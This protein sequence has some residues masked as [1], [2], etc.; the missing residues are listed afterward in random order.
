MT[1]SVEEL[2]F[3]IFLRHI[4]NEKMYSS[5]GYELSDIHRLA[6][7]QWNNKPDESRAI[8]IDQAQI[9]MFNLEKFYG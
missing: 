1:S 7:Q 4:L 3:F 5:Y 6:R 2:A 8:Y 9:E